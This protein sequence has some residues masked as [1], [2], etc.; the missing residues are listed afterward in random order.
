MGRIGEQPQG[1]VLLHYQERHQATRQR[2]GGLGADLRCHRARAAAGGRK[3]MA[4]RLAKLWQRM[5][6]SI[7]NDPRDLEFQ[8]EIEEHVTLLA[9]RYR[10]QGMTP[11]AAMLAARRQFGNTARLLEDRRD[12]RTLPTIEML[13]GDLAY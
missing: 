1:E 6:A 9:E 11:E 12:R 2:N 4:R 3:V 13:R 7:R 8:A 5:R 10:R